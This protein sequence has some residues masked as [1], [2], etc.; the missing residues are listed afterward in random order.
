MADY[1]DIW[2]PAKIF[3]P[4]ATR[5]SQSS[6]DWTYADQWLRTRYHPRPVPPFERT[7]DTLK[8]LLALAAANEAADDERALAKKVKEHTLEALQKRDADSA[9]ESENVLAAV[10]EHLTAE[11]VRALN[12]LALLAVA[13]GAERVERTE[14]ATR[15]ITLSKHEHALSQQSLHLRALHSRLETDLATLNGAIARL[16]HGGEYVVPAELAGQ[17]GEWGRATRHLAGKVDDYRERLRD[18]GERAGVTVEELIE[19]EREVLALKERVLDLEARVKGF[20]GLP[21]ERDLARVEVE[22]VERELAGL[23]ARRE[24][25]YD[26]MVGG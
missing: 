20:Q 17:V 2:S 25:L 23:E 16:A 19:K 4:T 22:R 10:E 18:E 15:L 5:H 6:K 21:P 9:G 8:A 24:A 26:N 13:V 12:S 1:R 14:L 7:P 3:S 11:G